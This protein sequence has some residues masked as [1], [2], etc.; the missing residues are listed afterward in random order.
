MLLYFSLNP[1]SLNI[2]KKYAAIF[3]NEKL[4]FA[5]LCSQRVFQGGFLQDFLGTFEN[6]TFIFVHFRRATPFLFD[7][8]IR[9]I[10]LIKDI[11]NEGTPFVGNC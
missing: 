10:Y 2:I 6:W 4:R 11:K 9:E 7:D 3:S 1:L 5:A 8:Y